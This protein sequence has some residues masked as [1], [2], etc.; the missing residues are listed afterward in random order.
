MPNSISF[1][2]FSYF[3]RNMFTI[4]DL[5]KK[6]CNMVERSKVSFKLLFPELEVSSARDHSLSTFAKFS[7]KLTNGVTNVV[8][9]LNK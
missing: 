6:K 3:I 8:K 1:Q 2:R 5:L 7:K 9:V 4:F